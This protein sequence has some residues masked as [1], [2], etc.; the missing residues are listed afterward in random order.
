MLFFKMRG[1]RSLSALS[2]ICLFF[3]THW[4]TAANLMSNPGAEITI[5]ATEF[6]AELKVSRTKL[7]ER[8]PEDWAL[9]NGS[10][11]AI[12]GA[13]DAEA[14][15]GEQSAYV[16]FE[17]FNPGSSNV[18]I[19]LCLGPSNGYKPEKAMPVK[20][21]RTF[22]F[23]FWAKGDLP[24]L[25]PFVFGWAESVHERNV[26]FKKSYSTSLGVFKPGEAWRQ[27]HGTFTLPNNVDYFLLALALQD[28]KGTLQKGQTI[29]VDDVEIVATPA[30]AK[31][32]DGNP[33][34]INVAVYAP[35]L[36][37][38]K[39]YI[40]EALTAEPG[41]LATNIDNLLPATLEPFDVLI[42]SLV[43]NVSR[44]DRVGMDSGENWP[45]AVLNFV[46][47]GKGVIMG[48]DCVG[49]R[50]DFGDLKLFPSI[51]IGAGRGEWV[52]NLTNLEPNHPV[53]QGLGDHFAHAYFDHIVIQPG[54]DGTVLAGNSEGNPVVAAGEL[55]RG[56]VLSIGYP[57]GLK[58][59]KDSA[60]KRHDSRVPLNDS[61]RQLL[62]NG[63]KWCGSNPQYNVPASRTKTTLYAAMLAKNNELRELDMD[64]WQDLP[65]PQFD[66]KETTIHLT[67][68]QFAFDTEEKIIQAVENVKAMG[69]NSI[70]TF[71]AS[72][73]LNYPSTNFPLD[74][75]E[76]RSGI[77]VD[78]NFDP[79]AILVREARKH[80][81]KVGFYV[82]PFRS[83]NYWEA[84]PG[85]NKQEAED[86]RAGNYDL[87]KYRYPYRFWTCADHP[88]A[89]EAAFIKARELIQN[90]Q[91]D[92]IWLDYIR[93][94]N[95]MTG[96]FCDHSLQALADYAAA[97]PDLTPAEARQAFNQHSI[98]SFVEEWVKVCKTEKPDI[99][100]CAYSHPEFANQ[101]PL[102]GH[103][104]RISRGL[105]DNWGQL[106]NVHDYT[107]RLCEWVKVY[108]P[109]CIPYPFVDYRD[110]KSGRRM[111]LEYAI[112]SYVMDQ[113][114][115]SNKCIDAFS[116][117]MLVDAEGKIAAEDLALGI[118]KALG[119]TWKPA[120]G[121]K[122]PAP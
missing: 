103:G 27:Y 22:R 54:D 44:A 18:N 117:T 79:L 86:Y 55:S 89:R 84:Y 87:E 115:V 33:D 69:F 47:R 110:N 75:L 25:R 21:R 1:C 4:A 82:C 24:A 29:Y 57:M 102:D 15:S 48:H 52:S 58:S 101:F 96:C 85:L 72:A 91:P 61:E 12:W 88:G 74:R 32:S 92:E 6:P 83:Q 17:K 104:Q 11:Y 64:K 39:E 8:V 62:I 80:N 5:P 7:A 73:R 3:T 28:D 68:L 43:K 50:G 70:K 51:G 95:E 2:F 90:Y 65:S 94:K 116:Y 106:Q 46:D 93:Y 81:M 121:Q 114:G 67:T 41:I 35:T 119:G 23:S 107:K 63:V 97:H 60:G 66:R 78:E 40:I 10:G 59:E 53:M 105:A 112:V 14:C 20:D 13:T 122:A 99:M 49:F 19:A 111:Y 77:K 76:F 37:Q 100:C 30:A 108:H 71:A 16:T 45:L 109:D 36:S 56:R 34:K 118:T 38:D 120:G 26:Y 98:L 31:L 42:C 113:A 9:Y